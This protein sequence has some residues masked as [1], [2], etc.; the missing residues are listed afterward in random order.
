LTADNGKKFAQHERIVAEL[1][2]GYY[3]AKPHAAWERGVN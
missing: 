1:K 3:F 2:L